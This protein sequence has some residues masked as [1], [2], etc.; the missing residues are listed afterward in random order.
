M[1]VAFLACFVG[2]AAVVVALAHDEPPPAR[3]LLA[4]T[5]RAVRAPEDIVRTD[6]PLAWR[7]YDP[8]TVEMHLRAVAQAWA[9]LLGIVPPEGEVGPHD[10]LPAYGHPEDPVKSV[11]TS[12]IPTSLR[13]SALESIAPDVD[14]EALRTHAALEVLQRIRY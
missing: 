14:A 1:F 7:G 10:P 13:S 2:M 9:D 5:A 12:P 8:A 3:R 4:A 6:F 11:P